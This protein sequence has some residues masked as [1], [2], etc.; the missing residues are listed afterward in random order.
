MFHSDQD[1]T[2]DPLHDSLILSKSETL[3]K[4]GSEYFWSNFNIVVMGID[5][6]FF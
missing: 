4:F 5:E 2:D 3:R 6:L 1:Y